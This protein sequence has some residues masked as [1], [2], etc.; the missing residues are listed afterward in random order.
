MNKLIGQH[1][2]KEEIIEILKNKNFL[3]IEIDILVCCGFDFYGKSFKKHEE[4]LFKSN[5]K[6]IIKAIK[7]KHTDE[8][9][10]IDWVLNIIDTVQ[11]NKLGLI[12]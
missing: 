12:K 7:K 9:Y 6:I 10:S 4:I 11:E 3:N 8:L 5:N 2:S 1:I